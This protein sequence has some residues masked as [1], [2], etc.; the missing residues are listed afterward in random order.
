MNRYRAQLPTVRLALEHL[1]ELEK[2][3]KNKE[4][5]FSREVVQHFT[6]IAKGISQLEETRRYIHEALEVETIEASKLRYKL[7]H[8]PNT[9]YQQ[10]AAAVAAA[11][12]SKA[13]RVKELQA[14][15]E[16]LTQQIEA[17]EKEYRRLEKENA[18]MC[19][20]Q[21]KARAQYDDIVSMLN[22]VL[23]ERTN[24]Q[25]TVNETHDHIKD[26]QQKT[27]IVTRDIADLKEDM[28]EKQK[29]HE[30]EKES[31]TA[32]F[33]EVQLQLQN[34]STINSE[35]RNK[36]DE[37]N[38]ELYQLN[39]NFSAQEE[40][41][42]L[43]KV[44][45]VNQKK[46][47]DTLQRKYNQKLK[48]AEE[49]IAQKDAIIQE[50]STLIE[51]LRKATEYL[52]TRTLQAQKD[53][54]DAEVFNQELKDQ[55]ESRNEAF[56]KTKIYENEIR[57]SLHDLTNRLAAT[58]DF[59]A[60]KEVKLSTGRKQIREYEEMIL[61]LVES[62]KDTME[63]LD[64]ELQKYTQ[65]L[66]K[67]R[68]IRV[69]ALRKRE[70]IAKEI[71]LTKRITEKYYDEMSQ[72]MMTMK[73][74]RVKL[75][76]ETRRLQQEIDE[77]AEKNAA[78]RQQLA[79]EEEAFSNIG[80]LLSTEI[81][82]LKNEI[83]NLK[84]SMMQTKEELHVKLS[85]QQELESQLAEET[86]VCDELQKELEDQKNEKS[87]LDNTII[88]L[89][90]KTE[91]LHSSKLEVKS[92]LSAMRNSLFQQIKSTAEQMKLIEG[93]IYEAGRRLEHV[94][95]ENCKLKLCNLQ[96]IKDIASL[97]EDGEKQKAAKK[98][99]D[100]KLQI[101]YENLQKSWAL[102][103]SV[104]K[105]YSEC[106]QCVLDAIEEL[107]KKTRHREQK[108]GSITE[109]L[110]VYLSKLLSFVGSTRSTE[111]TKKI[112]MRKQIKSQ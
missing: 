80:R 33:T 4:V 42:G 16:T 35:M 102:D 75:I 77:Y 76:A 98:K 14:K 28:E 48:A 108:V 10:L 105:E 15:V 12:E 83:R 81:E 86:K 106:E 67:E 54:K 101:I 104:Q 25:I 2:Q 38:L 39:D 66:E 18:S 72:H 68:Q 89:K 45:I 78:L 59:L 21:R 30:V 73:K 91:V 74:K 61:S 47:E 17:L 34:Q 1:Q 82:Q 13:T 64:G 8:L 57:E 62:H 26:T 29:E 53:T 3:L 51:T 41:T 99:Q 93:D 103:A 20:I 24:H 70:E 92:M 87:D 88:G 79:I 94:T 60:E 23:G 36:L 52:H 58:K 111:E 31:S 95:I 37:L 32:T 40:L 109:H 50:L 107:M 71:I 96:L 97:N 19:P 9:L 7:S 110:K 56:K 100:V 112:C 11:R 85:I 84:E 46:Q 49:L 44:E 27:V 5:C 65:K 55:R 69:T 43:L 90:I 6:Q 63:L 22:N